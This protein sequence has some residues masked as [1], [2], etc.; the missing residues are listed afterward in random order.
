MAHN[1]AANIESAINS[2]LQQPPVNGDVA[3]VIVVASGCTD[4]TVPIVNRIHAREPRVRLLLQPRREGKASAINLFLGAATSPILLMIG[5]DIVLKSGS[6]DALLQHFQDPS[7]GMV[8]AHPI[9]VNR[10]DTFLG[11]AAHL[12]WGLHDQVARTSPKLGEVVAFRNVVPSIPL[13]TPVDELSIQ[14]LVTQ[15]GYR[16]VY[17][18]SAIIY[19]RGPATVADF[20]RQR[21]RIYA[22]HLRIRRQQG[23]SASTMSLQ[24]ILQAL[25]ALQPLTTPRAAP[26]TLATIG[27]EAVA[28]SLGRYDYVRRRPSHVWQ[29][30]LSTKPQLAEVARGQSQQSILVFHIHGFHQYELELGTRTSLLLVQQI[31][32]QM[33]RTFAAE[34]SVSV[35]RSGTIIVQLPAGRDDAQREALPLITAIEAAPVR[36]NGHRHDLS[37]KLT[38][39]VITFSQTGQA[40]ALSLPQAT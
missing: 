37:I 17:E 39:G 5:A 10:D 4:D 18:P 20:L 26:W 21:R 29:M 33:R 28:R 23:Y 11:F 1:E 32:Q 25:L 16:L 13:D 40:L 8:G 27:L 19:N 3:E 15:L 14:A 9:P 6:L 24:R 31:A 35:E 12:L 7:V 30:A 2:I 22:G 38:C 34:A 36:V